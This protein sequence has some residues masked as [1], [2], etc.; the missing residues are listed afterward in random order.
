[1]EKIKI[2][3][4][5]IKNLF[6][7]A[8]NSF[9]R[10]FRELPTRFQWKLF[11]SILNKK[12]KVVFLVFLAFFLFSFL[13][14]FSS[15][16]NYK[17]KIVPKSGGAYIEGIVGQPRF[18][19]PILQS[20]DTDRDL[21]ELLFSGLM[22]Y[23]K[24]G[25]IVPDLIQDYEA[26]KNKT[27]Y[28]VTL[29]QDIF[30]HDG[31]EITADDVIFT[32]ETIQDPGFKSPEIANWLGIQVKKLS[33]TKILFELKEPYFP[34]L[35]RLTIK[36]A[37]KHIF[38][39]ISPENFALT[40]YN[41]EPIGSGPFK[42][43]NIQYAQSGKI[44]S[45][46]L[47]KNQ[48]YFDKVPYLEKIKFSFFDN[49][50]ALTNAFK[51]GQIQGLT[52]SE[53]SLIETLKANKAGLYNISLPRYFAVF[54]NPEKSSILA[55]DKV[56]QALNLATNKSEILEQALNN[57][58]KTTVS[59]ILP[60]F[61]E[62]NAPEQESNASDASGFN[63]EKAKQ[64][65]KDSG[66]IEKNGKFYEPEQETSFSFKKYLENGS[67][68]SEVTS[69]QKCLALFP[70]I[71]PD[72]EITG[73][74]GDAT[75]QAVIRFQ[76][77]YRQDILDPWEFDQGTGI[78][79]KTTRQKLN[80]VCNQSIEQ[81]APIT[82]T[83]ITVNQDFLIKT[84]EILKRQ[85]Q[86][87]GLEIQVKAFD[88]N[89]LSR[90]FIKPRNYEMLLFGEAL[91]IIP[92]PLAFWHSSRTSD[93]GLNL[94]MYESKKADEFLKKART[95]QDFETFKQNLEA[96]QNIL[97]EHNPAV[98]LYSPDF[99]YYVSKQIKGLEFN[100]ISDPSKRF[101]DINNWHTKTRRAWK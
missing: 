1:M 99:L 6:K 87:L 36:I 63:L 21:V 9:K 30:W 83:L 3:L 52:I 98:F 44:I 97:I 95:A 66:F 16:Y 27:M 7:R 5:K 29:K 12:E 89:E 49:Q 58:G 31:K 26:H 67:K 42:F 71:Y 46:S 74:F 20:N 35:E 34:F 33:N 77:K 61:Y 80:Q 92:D 17:T 45:F 65:L 47:I 38:E 62:F 22:K 69:L 24:N 78:V 84:A 57:Y 82:F 75:E 11:F 90:E 23:T 2:F 32:I 64:F 4:L 88:F 14:L 50:K 19:N 72:G 13:F 54:L 79:A 81:D 91:G 93:P 53:P 41:L 59:P 70:D 55:K 8:K 28:E 51:R 96:F 85:W 39:Q 76:E 60:D 56:R 15:A 10:I 100:I 18:I 25:E 40:T 43:K 68:G 101:L 73:Y 86:K 94:A 48:N 37:P